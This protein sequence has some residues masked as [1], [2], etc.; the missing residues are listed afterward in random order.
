[1]VCR[2]TAAPGSEAQLVGTA[3]DHGRPGQRAACRLQSLGNMRAKHVTPGPLLR[4][5]KHQLLLILPRA[6]LDAGGGGFDQPLHGRRPFSAA[7]RQPTGE[8]K[9]RLGGAHMLVGAGAYRGVMLLQ[10]ANQQLARTRRRWGQRWCAAPFGVLQPLPPAS[11]LSCPTMPPPQARSSH[12]S[13]RSHAPGLDAPERLVIPPSAAS[14][15]IS[16]HLTAFHGMPPPAQVE[17]LCALMGLTLPSDSSLLSGEAGLER[18]VS[19]AASSAG[20]LQALPPTPVIA[21]QPAADTAQVPGSDTQAQ[22][23][24]EGGPPPGD[25]APLPPSARLPPSPFETSPAHGGPSVGRR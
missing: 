25:D 10:R 18:A 1:M 7:H 12:R 4:R 2:L 9:S 15:G 24:A 11:L 13:G 3:A 22:P 17:E 5:C 23:G 14:H 16:L 8:Q 19:G 21:R 6:C 20:G